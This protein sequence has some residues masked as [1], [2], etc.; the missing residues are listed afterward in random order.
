MNI[1]VTLIGQAGTFLVFI[2]FT[3]YF[4]WPPLKQALQQRK[5]EI[6]EGLAAAERGQQEEANAQE[7]AEE[8]LR[9]ARARAAEIVDQAQKRGNELVEE[10]KE[11]ARAEGERIKQAART[12]IE[13]EITRAREELRGQVA[14]IAMA[15]AERVLDREVDAEAHNRMLEKL[16]AEL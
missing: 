4:V 14:A 6:A 2:L 7:R 11:S 15:G 13:Q 9:E 8:T 1:N 10:A 5:E 16:A 12:E 3:M